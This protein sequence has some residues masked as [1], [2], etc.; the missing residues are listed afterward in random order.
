MSG[1]WT[2]AD[3]VAAQTRME[4]QPSRLQRASQSPPAP[5]RGKYGNSKVEWQGQ[6]FDSKHELEDFKAFELQRIAGA[7]RAVIRQVSMPLPASR[8][9]IRIDFLV[10]ENDLTHRYYDSKGFMTPAW[11]SK[12]DQVRTAYG[13]DINLI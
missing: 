6:T 1:R 3:A 13:I 12:R 7:I 5:K 11:A 9:R 2:M 4:S 8:R 10:V